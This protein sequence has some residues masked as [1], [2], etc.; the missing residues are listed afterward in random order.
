MT[1]NKRSVIHICI[2]SVAASTSYK[3]H[4]KLHTGKK[5]AAGRLIV[6]RKKGLL[7]CH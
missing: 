4:R 2:Y 6:Q 7:C 3:D 1:T 5:T